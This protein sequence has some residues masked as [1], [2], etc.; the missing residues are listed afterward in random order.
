M[1]NYKYVERQKQFIIRNFFLLFIIIVFLLKFRLNVFLTTLKLLKNT[2]IF[3]NIN[4]KRNIFLRITYSML[5][6]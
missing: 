2:I 5:Q 4:Y 1:G 6:W 3:I